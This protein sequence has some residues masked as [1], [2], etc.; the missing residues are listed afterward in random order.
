MALRTRYVWPVV[1][2]L[3]LLQT[4]ALAGMAADRIWLLKTGKE[5]VVPVEPVDPRSLFRGDYVRLGFGFTRSIPE[6]KDH[7]SSPETIFVTLEKAADGSVLFK[8]VDR[9]HPG[10]VADNQFVLRGVRHQY[11]WPR[12]RFG[13]ESYFVP[14]G[15]GLA[16]EK[17]AASSKLAV[18]LAVDGRG[19]AAIKGLVVDGKTVYEEPLL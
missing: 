14:E 8:A 11:G 3:A 16:I 10:K 9:V 12:I 13:I 7:G 18:V 1:A 19:R 6:L 2:A 4:I 17:L 15:K 5:V